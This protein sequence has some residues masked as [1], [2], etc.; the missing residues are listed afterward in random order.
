MSVM[1]EDMT[2]IEVINQTSAKRRVLVDPTMTWQTALE[3]CDHVVKMGICAR[4]GILL[5]KVGNLYK[6]TDKQIASAWLIVSRGYS[7]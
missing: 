2:N 7:D 1:Y 6:Y 3:I 5:N 4:N